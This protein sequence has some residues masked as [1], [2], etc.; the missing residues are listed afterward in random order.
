MRARAAARARAL[1]SDAMHRLL[2]QQWM[3][4]GMYAQQYASMYSFPSQ[5]SNG[6]SYAVAWDSG[7]HPS[8]SVS[9]A[10]ADAGRRP[11]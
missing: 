7:S 6:A 1:A 8:A 2:Q 4:W 3:Q 11:F 5:P 9:V 10:E